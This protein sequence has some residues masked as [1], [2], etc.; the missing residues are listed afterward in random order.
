MAT[1][2]RTLSAGHCSSYSA[3]TKSIGALTFE[4]KED[5]WATSGEGKAKDGQVGARLGKGASLG[6]VSFTALKSSQPLR[7]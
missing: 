7:V 5:E 2:S 4:K 3:A 1:A 6:G